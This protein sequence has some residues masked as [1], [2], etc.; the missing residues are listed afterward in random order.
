MKA[1]HTVTAGEI[2]AIDCKRACGSYDKSKAQDPIH[3]VTAFAAANKVVLGQVK[4]DAKS[5]ESVPW[6]LKLAC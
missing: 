6:A 4:T 5:N 3:M 2:I 1:C